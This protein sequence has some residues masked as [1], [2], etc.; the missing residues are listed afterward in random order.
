M[1]ALKAVRAPVDRSPA[2][3]WDFNVH[4]STC[5]MLDVGN[6]FVGSGHSQLWSAADLWLVN[7]DFVTVWYCWWISFLDNSMLYTVCVCGG[8]GGSRY[9]PG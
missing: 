6:L 4:A 9:C 5:P 8:G 3:L 1:Y 7:M 2:I